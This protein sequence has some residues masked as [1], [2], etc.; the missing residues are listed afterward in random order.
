MQNF[1]QLCRRFAGAGGRG[2]DLTLGKRVI[3]AR[4]FPIS[5]DMARFEQLA[6]SPAVNARAEYLRAKLGGKRRIVLGLANQRVIVRQVDVSHL[7]EAELIDA[8]PYQVQDSIREWRIL[9][10]RVA[11][12]KSSIEAGTEVVVSG[13][14]ENPDVGTVRRIIVE[15][16]ALDAA[17][18][19]LAK[20]STSTIA[21]SNRER[22]VKCAV[23]RRLPRTARSSARAA[24]T[25]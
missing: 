19:V 14:I 6:A 23:P 15:V 18:N 9:M 17:G 16:E 25:G 2:G 20:T 13:V 5:I 8:L 12:L 11:E 10:P 3:R 22:S 24:G 1:C 7:E 21:I 4:A